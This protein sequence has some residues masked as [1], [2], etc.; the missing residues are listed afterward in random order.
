L[1]TGVPYSGIVGFSLDP[2]H[3]WK[4]WTGNFQEVLPALVEAHDVAIARIEGALNRSVA[5]DV[6]EIVSQLC[7][8]DPEIRGHPKSRSEGRNPFA[9]ERYISRLNLLHRRASLDSRKVA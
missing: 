1:L 3:G 2:A 6:S 5:A 9:L 4:S 8:P 7:H